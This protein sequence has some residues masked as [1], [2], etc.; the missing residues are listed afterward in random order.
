[1]KNLHLVLTIIT[2]SY[3]SNVLA[4]NASSSFSGPYVSLGLGNQ[5]NVIDKENVRAV[6]GAPSFDQPNASKHDYF[7]QIQAGYGIDFYDKFNV[8]LNAFY[9]FGGEKVNDIKAT[10]YQ[11]T[12]KQRLQNTAGIFIAPG[13]YVNDQTLVFLKAGWVRADKEYSRYR[14]VPN[15][16]VNVND[17]VD[18]YLWGVGIK[19]LVSTKL[20]I[21]ADLTRY[22][23]GS[24]SSIAN[25]NSLEVK[26]SSKS[27]Q[28]NALISVGYMF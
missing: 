10:L 15:I 14:Q 8:A 26:V 12:V 19:H 18:G 25:L 11:D 3:V 27:E 4:E 20:F 28:T 21:G 7:G 1:M 22:S 6:T 16:N 9:D 5:Y 24:S 23:Y 13:Y 2:L 17:S